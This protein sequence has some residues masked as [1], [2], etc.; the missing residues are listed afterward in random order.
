V[1]L[2]DDMHATLERMKRE[3]IKV[4]RSWPVEVHPDTL[5]DLGIDVLQLARDGQ[6]VVLFG[7]T[8]ILNIEVKR[9][10]IKWA[11]TGNPS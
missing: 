6:K 2:R 5:E 7:H 4:K 1:S 3:G 9:G 8:V 10:C 11:Q